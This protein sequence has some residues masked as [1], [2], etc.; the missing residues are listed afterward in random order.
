MMPLTQTTDG[1]FYSPSF[2]VVLTLLPAKMFVQKK[3]RGELALNLIWQR[4]QTGRFMAF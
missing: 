2:L 4:L 3:I 1:L